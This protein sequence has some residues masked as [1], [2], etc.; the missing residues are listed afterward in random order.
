MSYEFLRPGNS[1]NFNTKTNV[2]KTEYSGVKVLGTVSSDIAMTL[3]DVRAMHLQVKPYI[4]GLPDL[5]SDYTYVIIQ[6]TSGMKDVLGLPW[7][8]ESSISLSTKQSYQL[9]LDNIEPEQV[10]IIRASLVNRAIEIRS[11]SVFNQ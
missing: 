2:L 6:H 5:F 3:Q 9:I 11:F 7:L 8:L 1:V 10:E 4:T